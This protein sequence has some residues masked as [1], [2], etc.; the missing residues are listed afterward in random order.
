M[1]KV[2]EFMK[3]SYTTNL[4]FVKKRMKMES[5]FEYHKYHRIMRRLKEEWLDLIKK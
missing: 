5:W 2:H 1:D 4:D 3:I